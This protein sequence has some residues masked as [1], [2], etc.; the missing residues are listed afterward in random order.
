MTC[1][2][3]SSPV[4]GL[5]SSPMSTGMKVS[6]GK[7]IRASSELKLSC[8]ESSVR[9]ISCLLPSSLRSSR[10][11][12]ENCEE[13]EEEPRPK[14][15]K[16]EGSPPSPSPLFPPGRLMK[17]LSAPLR[18][19]LGPGR[20]APSLPGVSL[21]GS[22]ASFEFFCSF[23][24]FRLAFPTSFAS[25]WWFP[26]ATAVAAAPRELVF[27]RLLAGAASSCCCCCCCCCCFG[28]CGASDPACAG[29]L[30]QRGCAGL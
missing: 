10:S 15:W 18:S 19:A 24:F 16:E 21:G 23:A 12:G 28:G 14:W 3:I 22:M 13:E 11:S 20:I 7:E 30:K 27:R 17:K 9:A 26:A 8:S 29:L 1:P 5:L 4:P 6:M 2:E 25:C